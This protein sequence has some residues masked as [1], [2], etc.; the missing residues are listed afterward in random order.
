MSTTTL[1]VKGPAVSFY[2]CVFF[3]E[4]LL[5]AQPRFQFL[6]EQK[7]PLLVFGQ[8]HQEF[9]FLNSWHMISVTAPDGD[10]AT[11]PT[12][13]IDGVSV[14]ANLTIGS[15]GQVTGS[16]AD[17]RIGRRADGVTQMQ[18]SIDDVRIYNRALFPRREVKQLYS[19]GLGTKS[20]T[21]LLAQDFETDY[22]GPPPG[23]DQ[24]Y[25]A[26]D[27]HNT[28]APIHGTASLVGTNSNNFAGA[29][30]SA[31]SDVWVFGAIANNGGGPIFDINDP[32]S[33]EYIS[34]QPW[35]SSNFRIRDG[36]HD[37]FPVASFDPSVGTSYFWIHYV[38]G[39]G[40]NA[41]MQI[42]ASETTTRPSSPIGSWSD[43]TQTHAFSRV[44]FTGQGGGN[45]KLDYVRVDDAPIGSAPF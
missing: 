28:T 33:G 4:Q 45:G 19:G 11:Q 3:L 43:G 35:G 40:S 10:I 32:I 29:G 21:Y 26:W 16:G 31:A 7:Q 17:I 9:L 38:A 5:I 44:G 1:L 14:T 23:W 20:K 42:Y 6:F 39:T 18:G 34:I 2:D 36:V 25:A 12:F 22:G 8:Q 30:F 13:Y 15:S 27:W 41:Q 37:Y 24:N